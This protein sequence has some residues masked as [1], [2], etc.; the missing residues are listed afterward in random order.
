MSPLFMGHLKET[1]RAAA[2]QLVVGLGLCALGRCFFPKD[3]AVIFYGHRVAA[4]DEGYLEGLRPEWLDE[5]LAYLTRH[6]EIISL[7]R[8][9]ECY[10][11]RRPVPPRSVVL[12]FDDGFRDNLT[13]G[14]PVLKRYGVTATIFVVTG[15]AETGELPWPQRLGFLF[16]H[17]QRPSLI[18]SWDPSARAFMELPLQTSTQRREAYLKLKSHLQCQP[19]EQR[20]TWLKRLARELDVDPPR[21]RMLSWEDLREL[22]ATGWEIGAHTY[23]HPWLAQIPL[24][25]AFQEMERSREDLHHHLGLERPS[26]CFPAG[27]YNAALMARARDLGFRSAFQP[28]PPHRVNTLANAHPFALGR[29]GLPNA[30]AVNMEAELDGP[31][32]T[33]RRGLYRLTGK[34]AKMAA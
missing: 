21:D 7:S 14:W 23:S 3:G 9:L 22:Q 19:R 13:H 26:F 18:M 12:T 15:C 11:L 8:L 30:P 24:A 32:Y 34:G 31:F 6:Y 25:E 29:M 28:N 2:S 20:E 4:D 16:Q 1:C 27:S 33:L 17:T 10:E 5:Q